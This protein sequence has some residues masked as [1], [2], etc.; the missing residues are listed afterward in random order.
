[1]SGSHDH[2]HWYSPAHLYHHLRE[3]VDRLYR[4]VSE[5]L[6]RFMN[7]VIIDI[8][9]EH[10]AVI[11]MVEQWLHQ[12]GWFTMRNRADNRLLVCAPGTARAVLSERTPDTWDPKPPSQ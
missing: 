6:S 9:R 4:E 2:H 8:S 1:M 7:G 5:N 12:S 11:A 10:Q 3:D